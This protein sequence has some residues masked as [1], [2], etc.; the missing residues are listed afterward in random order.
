MPTLKVSSGAAS[1]HQ[2]PCILFVK[3]AFT[4]KCHK[5]VICFPLILF[6]QS[7]DEVD[8]NFCY[9]LVTPACDLTVLRSLDHWL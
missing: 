2:Q 9:Y 3:S 4:C 1:K 5:H 8:H 6:G 7:I